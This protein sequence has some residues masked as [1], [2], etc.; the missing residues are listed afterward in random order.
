VISFD[1]GN[2]LFI[3]FLQPYEVES[4]NT[5]HITLEM[6]SIKKIFTCFHENVS[7]END[8]AVHLRARLIV[9][10]L[11]SSIRRGLAS[12]EKLTQLIIH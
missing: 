8:R 9:S 6:I 11:S 7:F 10:D 2:Q 12:I 1:G 4:W 5:Y 3:I